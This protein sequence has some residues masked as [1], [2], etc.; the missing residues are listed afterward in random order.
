MIVQP[1]GFVTQQQ[2]TCKKN[3]NDA[4]LSSLGNVPAMAFKCSINIFIQE[5]YTNKAFASSFVEATTKDQISS[6]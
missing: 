1:T 6:Q 5:N 2:I 4:M 3:S